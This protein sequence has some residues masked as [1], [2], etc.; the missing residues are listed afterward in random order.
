LHSRSGSSGNSGGSSGAANQSGSIDAGGACAL[1]ACSCPGPVGPSDP[2][3]WCWSPPPASCPMDCPTYSPC[4][5][6]CLVAALPA[7]CSGSCPVEG[8]LDLPT[9]PCDGGCGWLGSACAGSAEACCAGLSCRT[10]DGG[11][12]EEGTCCGP[13]GFP[14]FGLGGA[15][16]GACCSGKCSPDGCTAETAG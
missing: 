2:A 7:P 1:A 6:W 8:G 14:C 16:D 15:G 10:L 11:G 5:G 12:G 3:G 4:Q 9:I 13:G